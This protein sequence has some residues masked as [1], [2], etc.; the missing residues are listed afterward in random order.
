MTAGRGIRHS[1]FNASKTAPV[2][3]LQVWIEPR[4]HS[5]EPSYEERDLGELPIGDLRPVATHDGRRGSAVIHQDAS[6]WAARLNEGQTVT[7]APDKGRRIWLHVA[8]GQITLNGQEL[9]PGDAASI[10]NESRLELTAGPGGGEILLF[11][12]P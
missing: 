3:L 4:E 12:L 2:H 1:E 8:Q 5:L 6:I 11:D 10:E 7:H 9:N